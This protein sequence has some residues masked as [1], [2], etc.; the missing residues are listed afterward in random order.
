M[1]RHLIASSS[2]CTLIWSNQMEKWTCGKLCTQLFLLQV[3][4]STSFLMHHIWWRQQETASSIPEV[5]SAHAICGTMKST[6]SGNTLPS[7]ITRILTRV[8]ISCPSWQLITLFLS[9]IQRW[10]SA[11]QCKCW[12]IQLHKLYSTINHQ[13]KYRKPPSCAR[14]SMIFST[15]W[16]FDQP[17]SIGRSAMLY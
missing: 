8:C 9:H 3:E 6:Y 12:E 16:M 1:G 11:W 4:K 10:K 5:V 2:N 15:A 14:W 13:G 7:F 17:P